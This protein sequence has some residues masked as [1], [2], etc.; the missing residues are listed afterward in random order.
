MADPQEQ[1]EQAR[2]A[3]LR[4]DY[5]EAYRLYEQLL[6]VEPE[7]P[8]TL[9]DYGR[10]K[11]REYADLEGATGLFLRL[12]AAQPGS[13]EAQLWLGDLYSLGYGAGYP[14][15]AERYRAA[16]RL[17]PREVDAYIGL[18]MLHRAPSAAVTLDQA[19]EAFRAAVELEPTRADARVDLG[20]ALLEA[21]Q[22]EDAERELVAAERL[23]RDAG[24]TKQAQ[25]IRA[26]IDW[27]A[28]GRA[29]RPPAY[30]NQSPR[31]RWPL[32]P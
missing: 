28:T 16:M 21:E 14:A 20:M 8:R 23:L 26:L 5:A 32:T 19:V 29:P 7:D 11:Y 6:S 9:L 1:R 10:A 30:S 2:L 18:G 25:G 24:E 17:D 27:L 22:R 15:A 13:V 4:G 3:C 31:Y 12:A